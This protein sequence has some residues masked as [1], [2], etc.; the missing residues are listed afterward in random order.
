MLSNMTTQPS[1]F[2]MF[3][4]MDPSTYEAFHNDPELLRMF[5]DGLNMPPHSPSSD[6]DTLN[7]PEL[8]AVPVSDFWNN[9]GPEPLESMSFSPV[10]SARHNQVTRKLISYCIV[11]RVDHSIWRFTSSRG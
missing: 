6:S 3:N 10:S 2:V 9:L 4:E 11:F 8:Y 1:D 5:L 7:S